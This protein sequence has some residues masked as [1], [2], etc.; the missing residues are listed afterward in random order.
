MYGGYDS[1]EH[2]L[3]PILKAIDFG[4]GTDDIKTMKDTLP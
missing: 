3:A 4:E 2:S 1:E